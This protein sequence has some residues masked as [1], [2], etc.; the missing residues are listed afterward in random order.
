MKKSE[1]QVRFRDLLEENKNAIRDMR[2][3][4]DYQTSMMFYGKVCGIASAMRVIG[5]I[6]FDQ[7]SE[8]KDEAW[9]VVEGKEPEHEA[10]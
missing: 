1:M 7:E 2:D 6:D 4:C 9:A 8:I 10:C 3:E 5:L